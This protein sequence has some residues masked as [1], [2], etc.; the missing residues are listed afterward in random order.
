MSRGVVQNRSMQIRNDEMFLSKDIHIKKAFAFSCKNLS[1]RFVESD[2]DWSKKRRKSS[3]DWWN[4]SILFEGNSSSMMIIGCS[5]EVRTECSTSARSNSCDER[6]RS[7]WLIEYFRCVEGIFDYLL[8]YFPSLFDWLKNIIKW[9]TKEISQS[10]RTVTNRWLSLLT[11]S[12]RCL[13]DF[14][15]FFFR[16]VEKKRKNK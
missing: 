16:L 10:N 15:V 3:N 8:G 11:F 4:R 14:L 1:L 7:I 12:L 13:A 6:I 2:D 5:F 9:M